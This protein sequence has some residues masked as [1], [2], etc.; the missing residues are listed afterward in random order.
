V[1][2]VVGLY[3]LDLL[4]C[5]CTNMQPLEAWLDQAVLL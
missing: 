5:A 3:L 1:A 2:L 4:L